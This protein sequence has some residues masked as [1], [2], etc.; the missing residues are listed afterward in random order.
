MNLNIA[1]RAVWQATLMVLATVCASAQDHVPLRLVQTILVPSIKGRIDH[2]D[3]DV[4]R[5]RLFVA[6]LEN[7]S[8]EVIDL[9]AG[10]WTRSIP[11]FQ[12]PQGVQYVA[13]LNKLFVASGNDGMLRIFRGDSLK[14]LKAL[15]LKKGANR[16][17]YDPSRALLYVGY[18]GKDAGQDYGEVGIVDANKDELIAEIEVSAHPAELLLDESGERVFCFVPVKNHL[19]VIDTRKRAVI[20]TWPASSQKPGDGAYDPSTSR[21][22]LGTRT[23]PEMIAMNAQNGKEVASLPTGEAMDGV[24]FDS[25]RKRVYVSGGRELDNGYVY[26]YQQ[27]SADQYRL[28]GRVPTRPGA[29]TSLWVP[30]L[31]RYY[32][33]A[34]A[35]GNS[36]ATILV[37]APVE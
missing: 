4:E 37:F 22:L 20:A 30:A 17:A 3:A 36:A 12:K 9:K 21:L 28:A 24:Y 19:Q 8:L 16:V 15:A 35:N 25:K 31:N 29:G 27:E 6:G 7:G 33:A 5:Q 2:M 34:P 1:K 10:K 23:P 26:V 13:S 14:L 18:G 11:G 32:V